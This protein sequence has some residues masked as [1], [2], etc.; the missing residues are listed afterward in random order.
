ML[1]IALIREKPEWV[2]EQIAKL[3]DLEAVG[4]IDQIVALDQRR[5]CW[6]RPSRF[7]PTAISSTKAV[8]MLRGNKKL[9]DTQKNLRAGRF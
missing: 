1:D 6:R 4:R 8:G 9:D 3:N 7:S 2:K 5:R